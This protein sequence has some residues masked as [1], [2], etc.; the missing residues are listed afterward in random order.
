MNNPQITASK[1]NKFSKIENYYIPNKY[2]SIDE[3]MISLY[4]N[5]NWIVFIP[6]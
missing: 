1:D 2:L 3:F 4:G 5:H 6:S